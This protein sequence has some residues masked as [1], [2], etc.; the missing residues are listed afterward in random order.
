LY[1][2]SKQVIRNETRSMS[3]PIFDFVHGIYLFFID[4][5]VELIDRECTEGD[6]PRE[7][8]GCCVCCSQNM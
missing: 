1:D 3:L 4:T 2:G 6:R 5:E 8:P 7:Y